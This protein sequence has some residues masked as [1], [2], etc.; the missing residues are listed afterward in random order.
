LWSGAVTGFE[1]S[2]QE[3]LVSL[4]DGKGRVSIPAYYRKVLQARSGT[5]AEVVIGY[6]RKGKCLIG[7]DKRQHQKLN[8]QLEEKHQ[9]AFDPEQDK[10]RARLSLILN[11]RTR[12]F[13]LDEPGRVILPQSFRDHAGIALEEPAVFVP[14]GSHFEIWNVADAQADLEAEATGMSDFIAEL[15]QPYLTR[16]KK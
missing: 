5:S 2:F 9:F 7:Y 14:R 12:T 8:A 10:E 11:G 16:K 13:T 6:W 1:D 15:V 4:V 3:T